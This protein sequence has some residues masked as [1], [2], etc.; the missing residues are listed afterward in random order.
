[1]KSYATSIISPA[2]ELTR[3]IILPFSWKTWILLAIITFFVGQAGFNVPNLTIPDGNAPDFMSNLAV[4]IIPAIIVLAL[5]ALVF[6]YLQSIFTFV[7]FDTIQ[8]KKPTIRKSYNKFHQLGMSYFF[9]RLYM[10]AIAIGILAAFGGSAYLTYSASIAIPIVLVIL[11]FLMLAALA[12]FDYLVANVVIVT[13]FD[14][15]LH[16]LDAFKR[17]WPAIKNQVGEVLLY[18]VMRIV[19][20]I[21][22]GIIA[23]FVLFSFLIVVVMVAGILFLLGF[24]LYTLSAQLLWPLIIIGILLAI[25]LLLALFLAVTIFTMPIPL[26]FGVYKLLFAR[27][28]LGKK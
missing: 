9:Y 16:F 28:L 19:L 2:Y 24:A 13:M 23:L 18:F 7:L 21:L 3:K 5:F 11:G 22:S 17:S 15:K 12:V 26:Y 14:K 27:K 25:P 20:G 4:I 10:L 8:Q 1:M 6:M